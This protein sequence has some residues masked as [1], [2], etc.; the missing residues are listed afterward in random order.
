MR[1][2]AR[3]TTN[4]RASRAQSATRVFRVGAVTHRLN[5]IPFSTTI[6]T[7]SMAYRPVVD[8]S[9]LPVEVYG[10]IA[11]GLDTPKEC[12]NFARTC[13][14]VYYE[15]GVRHA[16]VLKLRGV[17]DTLEAAKMLGKVR[18]SGL[19]FGSERLTRSPPTDAEGRLA[20]VV[21][22]E[23][24]RMDASRAVNEAHGPSSTAVQCR[25]AP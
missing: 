14:H 15:E 5:F 16:A 19:R 10:P 25:R 12:I 9:H 4:V 11:M 6:P 13:Q 24:C 7:H 1:F 17:F 22:R 2:C 20:M 18:G 8:F 3:D 23:G 21:C